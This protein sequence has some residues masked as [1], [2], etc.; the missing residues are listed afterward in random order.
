VSR[1]V[2][3]LRGVNV[4]GRNRIAMADLRAIAG[5]LGYV[6]A[7][8]FI[9]S[10]NLVF[11]TPAS[12]DPYDAESAAQALRSAIAARLGL[13]VDVMVR[14]RADLLRILAAVP[15]PHAVPARVLIVFL[16]DAPT[17]EACAA[18]EEAAAW[19]EEVRIVGREA[20]LHL[21]DGIGRSV[22]APLVE[23]RLRVRGTGRNLATTRALLATVEAIDGPEV[24]HA[25]DGSVD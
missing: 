25:A 23:R 2:A 21:P 17:P 12:M 14:D 15:Y 18:L 16:A 10:G 1:F 6:D 7:T 3:L 5:S 8:T 20:F 24:R 13:E 4:G 19:P 9:Q 22:L 11:G